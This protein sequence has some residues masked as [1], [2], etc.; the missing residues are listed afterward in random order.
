M[1]RALSVA[2]V[3][4]GL[5]L[6]AAGQY[7]LAD[8]VQAM[9][10]RD[11]R[12]GWMRIPLLG[13]RLGPGVIGLVLGGL[14]GA[15]GLRG[16]IA[17]AGPDD[18][19]APAPERRPRRR[20]GYA[21]IALGAAVSAALCAHIL[22]S[23][24]DA[25]DEATKVL[26]FA[27]VR[28]GAFVA[29]VLLAGAG[30]AMFGRREPGA[31]LPF[32]RLDALWV[33]AMPALFVAL[34]VPTL[35]NWRYSYIGDEYAFLQVAHEL[36]SGRAFDPFW[37][38]GVYSTH[39]LLSSWIP[40]LTMRLFGADVVGWKLGLVAM[41]VLAIPITYLA[42]RWLFDRTTGMVAA[43]VVATSHYLFA[44]SHTGHNNIDSVPWV[45][46]TALLVGVAL[47][48]PSP[49]VW[50]AA[51]ATAG[52]SLYWFFAARVA[53]PMIALAMLQRGPRRFRDGLAP[54]LLGTAIVAAPFLARNQAETVTRMLLESAT[55]KPIPLGE[56]LVE[57]ARLTGL[58]ALAFHWSTAHGLYIS[59]GLL[60]PFSAALSALGVG[61]A[62]LHLRDWRRRT[63]LIWY[64]MILL[65]TGGLAR[66]SSISVP[67]HL[68]L[69]PLMAVFVGD[70]VSH[71]LRA[72]APLSGRA[73]RA[74]LAGLTVVALVALLAGANVHRFRIVTPE[75][76]QVLPEMMAMAALY[77]PRCRAAG[78]FPIYV[79]GARA[80]AMPMMLSMWEPNR[81]EPMA[82]TEAEYFAVPAYQRWPCAVVVDPEGQLA[83]RALAT[84]LRAGQG[85]TSVEIRDDARKKGAL[86]IRHPPEAA[87][88]PTP[89][90]QWRRL[91]VV[92]RTNARRGAAFGSIAESADLSVGP[93]GHWYVAD[94]PNRRVTEFDAEG[95]PIAEWAD[96]GSLELPIG[97]AGDDQGVVAIDQTGRRLVVFGPD[98]R[99]RLARSWSELGLGQPRGVAIEWDG[100]VV[101]ADE[102]NAKLVRFSRAL[103]QIGTVLEQPTEPD[104]ARG[105]RP[106]E[107]RAHP[108]GSLFVYEGTTFGRVRRYNPD[109]S[110]A[111]T[112]ETGQREGR[113]GPAPDRGFWVGGPHGRPLQ[114]FGP[115]GERTAEYAPGALIGGAGEGGVSGLAEDANGRLI[116]AWRYLSVVVYRGLAS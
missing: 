111:G 81:Y 59:L 3:V 87:P 47:V 37:Q 110:I 113:V 22:T 21:L 9:F 105:M 71:L 99:V 77:D 82:V 28:P 55:T 103:E 79:G 15:L 45:I 13:H 12:F 27:Y 24:P 38:A 65:I 85:A 75:R 94:P 80:G 86:L 5:A 19:A 1:R 58:S 63:M 33:L 29:S 32:D 108:D 66:H 36:Y 31:R 7:L 84:A 64:L 26:Y 60:D 35:A 112:W 70:A 23:S 93:N 14:L 16:L 48:R 74:P 73:L 97:A 2:A 20:L 114:R 102:G 91:Y 72:L 52:F 50:F 43:G 98:R 25:W 51:G 11:V 95:T 115:N 40:A 90:G 34:V 30:C 76:N 17:D 46:L 57:I 49:L 6:L 8:E 4:L 92:D 62:L 106:S 41:G 61:L 101:V 68:V 18:A 69:V 78:P 42:G 104:R 54:A 107:V 67:R 96:R 10:D 44:Y 109:G 39:P 56:Q 116:V 53:G 83:T 88:A 100:N 89:P